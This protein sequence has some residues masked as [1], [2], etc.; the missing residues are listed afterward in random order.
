MNFANCNCNQGATVEDLRAYLKAN[1]TTICYPMLEVVKT[2]DLSVV[3]QTGNVLLITENR[4]YIITE[5]GDYIQVGTKYKETELSTFDDIT[6]VTVSSEGLVPTG[7][8]TVATKDATD[9]IDAG[10]M[11]LRMDDIL[12]S[13]S[14][15]EESANAQSDDIDVTMLGATDIYEQ[16][17]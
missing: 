4:K 1:P 8:I 11:S 12:N 5:N 17:L 3:D 6:H 14:T 15:L 13:Q 7:E 10:V 2:V 16:L 9:V